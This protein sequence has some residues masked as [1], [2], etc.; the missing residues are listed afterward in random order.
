MVA[1]SG[2]PFRGKAVHSVSTVKHALAFLLPIVV[3]ACVA[4]A[5]QVTLAAEP[6]AE[7][8]AQPTPPPSVPVAIPAL[9]DTLLPSL[10]YLERDGGAWMRG[11]S[12]LN[13]DNGCISCHVVGFAL[14]SHSAAARNGVSVNSAGIEQLSEQAI[15][16]IGR[17]RI[18]RAVTWSQLLLGRSGT[19]NDARGDWAEMVDGTVASQE[20]AGHW[21]AR[22]QFPTQR[23]PVAESDAVATMWSLLALDSMAETRGSAAGRDK[24]L[25]WIAESADGVSI[26][27]LAMRVL[28]ELH[29]GDRGE[30][31]D[32]LTRLIEEQRADGGWSW[33]LTEGSEG[34][35]DPSNAYSTGVA[36]YTLRR[37]G[38]PRTHPAALAAV[39]YLLAT[40]RE[41]GTWEL[42]SRLISAKPSAGKDYIY[43]YWGTAWA[44][45]GLSE[46]LED[47]TAG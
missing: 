9:E 43:E 34:A 40:H 25:A 2:N 28:T 22:G 16:F 47:S 26:E 37:A 27:W 1:R 39:D 7:S 35:Q 5:P 21:R 24:A 6:A 11:E 38:L 10:I 4:P 17:P 14:W 12:P 32:L 19:A 15:E 31:E 42:P 20:R 41:D 18:G 3:A 45:I 13:R 23:R 36:L 8:P 29:F 30:R 46:M 44:V 33:L